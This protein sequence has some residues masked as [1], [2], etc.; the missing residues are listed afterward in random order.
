MTTKQM[1]SLPGALIFE[2]AVLLFGMNPAAAAP[3]P[4]S[5]YGNLPGFETAALSPSGSKV[6]LIGTV[7]GSRR[8]IIQKVDGELIHQVLIGDHKL[9]DIS[10]SG[11]DQVLIE[12]T[13]TVEL[14]TDFVADKAELRSIGVLAAS[15]GDLRWIFSRDTMIPDVV[16]GT[17]GF[18]ERKGERFGYFGGLTLERGTDGKPRLQSG[19][20]DLY[21]VNMKTGTARRIAFH[22]EDVD[23]DWVVDATGE[24]VATLDMRPDSGTWTLK[25][26]SSKI[27]ATGRNRYG[28]IRL[29]GLGRTPGTILYADQD[30]AGNDNWFELS[31]AGGEP[32]TVLDGVGVARRYEDKVTRQLIGYSEQGDYPVAHFFDTRRDKI[33][34]ATHRA[35]PNRRMTIVDW[36][37]SFDHLI[38]NT[39]GS[40]DAGAWWLVDIKT[41]AA[42]DLGISYP[43]APEDVG[44]V[45]MVS[46]KAADGLEMAGV[47]TLPPG[48]EAKNL[49]VI[50]LPHGGPTSRD[51]PGFYWWAQAL[52]SRGYAV[53]QPNFRG[54]SGYTIAFQRAGHGQWGRKMQT[55]IS[56]GLAEL[57]R[58]GIVDPKRACIMGASYGGYAALAGV[59]L[60]Q[61]LYRCAVSVAGIGDVRKMV[62]SEQRMA[63]YDRT[64]SR[65]LKQEIGAGSNLEAISPINFANKADAPILLIHGKDDTVVEFDQSSDMAAA[66]RRA[67]KPVEFLT[68]QGEDH[69]LSRSQTRLAM[70]EAAVAFVEKHNP[71]DEAAE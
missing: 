37:D 20:P 49:P 68:L 15:G 55:D 67:K 25:N 41:R 46:Y 38:V 3:P 58:Q 26:A 32:V 59:T 34:K 45:K 1:R 53:F 12:V 66:L 69:W 5:I 57:A 60:Q 39:E 33:A 2:A 11:E 6:A 27:I 17:Y 14:G 50:M 24:V 64:L 63:G 18:A 28:R 4:L 31:L 13:S 16:F 42:K 30:E 9:R 62:A 61:G 65:A 36:S 23:R 7:A 51:Y 54:S 56:D 35:F 29:L 19:S 10:W 48:R 21:E 22:G 8:L 43:L 71:P 52:A 44:Q 47:L 40:E 70:L